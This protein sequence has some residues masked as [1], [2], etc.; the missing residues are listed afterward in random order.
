MP[1][2]GL[3]TT[4]DAAE[5]LDVHESTIHRWVRSG[6]LTIADRGPGETGA[7]LFDP[8]EIDRAANQ[9]AAS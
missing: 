2:A 4:R 8:A 5:R 1:L 9:A 6:R 3:L 7:L